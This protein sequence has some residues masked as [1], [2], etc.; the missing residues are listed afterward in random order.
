M[1][2]AR[3]DRDLAARGRAK[4]VGTSVAAPLESLGIQSLPQVAVPGMIPDLF[5]LQD[6]HVQSAGQSVRAGENGPIVVDL[7]LEE[8]IGAAESPREPADLQI[9]FRYALVALVRIAGG[10]EHG[11][12][13]LLARGSVTRAGEHLFHLG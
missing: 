1:A 6:V 5:Q 4:D 3:S 9:I 13:P 7:H 12:P 10:P 2:H 8:R 11:E